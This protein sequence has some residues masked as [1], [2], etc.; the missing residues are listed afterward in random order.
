MM[1]THIWP[2]PASSVGQGLRKET[3]ASDSTSVWE[4][5]VPL[6]L[7][8][9]R[10]FSFSCMFL[11]SFELLPHCRNS[12]RASPSKSMCRHFKRNCLGLHQSF[13][14]SATIPTGFHQRSYMGFFFPALEPWPGGLVWGWSSSLLR[15]YLCSWD[16][17][18]NFYSLHMGMGPAMCPPL[19][20]VSAWLLLYILSCRTSIHLDFRQFWMMVVLQFSCNSDVAVGGFKSR[21]YL[22]YRLDW[23]PWIENC[24][25]IWVVKF[26]FIVTQGI[27]L[28]LKILFYIW[29]CDLPYIPNTICVFWVFLDQS[30]VLFISLFKP[31]FSFVNLVHGILKKF[32]FINCKPHFYHSLARSLGKFLFVP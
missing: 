5:V 20:P 15:G 11:V 27:F 17:P 19:L 13:I 24:H 21:I 26:I 12:E 6:D 8:N 32:F 25:F 22:C 4:K 7:P 1:E 16:M 10:Y 14:L 18:P 23:K 31:T 28:F 2:L 9:S 3:T 30:D 29:R